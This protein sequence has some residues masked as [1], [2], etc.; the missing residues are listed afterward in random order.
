VIE[1]DLPLINEISDRV[2]AMESGRVLAVGTPAEVTADP[3]VADAGLGGS[4]A[5]VARSGSMSAAV[6]DDHAPFRPPSAD[7]RA[8]DTA[9]LPPAD[10]RC[11]ALT[12]S[13]TRCRRGAVS[14]GRCRQHASEEVIA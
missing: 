7:D 13:G 6:A 11:T 3:R 12:R 10:G 9:E 2:V 4:V 14:G 8:D 5:A 1:H